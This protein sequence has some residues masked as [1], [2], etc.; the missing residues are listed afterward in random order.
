M[1]RC[2][3]LQKFTGVARNW[4][5]TRGRGQCATLRSTV[6]SHSYIFIQF[7]YVRIYLYTYILYILIQ[8]IYVH[9]YLIYFTNILSDVKC[10]ASINLAWPDLCFLQFHI[11]YILKTLYSLSDLCYLL[12][13]KF[14]CAFCTLYQSSMYYASIIHDLSFLPLDDYTRHLIIEAR[15]ISPLLTKTSIILPC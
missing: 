2:L 15:L 7:I 8:F 9:I 14:Y 5:W 4:G 10:Y 6:T 3:R 11:I 1:H 12:F 13:H